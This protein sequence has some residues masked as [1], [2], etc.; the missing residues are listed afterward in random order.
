MRT[1]LLFYG[2]MAGVAFVWRQLALSEPLLYT[3]PDEAAAGVA[4]LRDLGAG[5]L[6]GGVVIL[7]SR[8]FTRRFRWGENLARAMAE[9]LGPLRTGQI[10]IL[11]LVSGI[12]EEAFFRGAL[13]PRVGLLLASLLFGLAHLVPRADWLPWSAFALVVGLL[14]GWL[15]EATGNLVAPV[16]AHALVNGVNLYF[17]TRDYGPVTP[18]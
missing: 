9:V 2:A 11:A 3:T 16:V 14:L 15:F 12:A 6:A 17:L 7:I 5:V 10:A 8:E 1:A 4:W 18:R 13:Q